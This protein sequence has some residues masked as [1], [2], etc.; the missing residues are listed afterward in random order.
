MSLN[1][2]D[3]RKVTSDRSIEN[4]DRFLRRVKGAIKDQLPDIIKD[5]SLKDIDSQGGKVR[6]KRK[7]IGEP[8]IHHGE[9]GE[10]DRVLPGNQKYV[11]DDMIPKP[12]EGA[13]RGRRASN[14]GEGE[15]DLIIDLSRDEFLKYFFEDLELPHLIETQLSKLKETFRENAG[16]QPDGSP[17]RLSVVR[18][19]KQSLVRRTAIRKTYEKELK[20]LEE[21]LSGLAIFDLDLEDKSPAGVLAALKDPS[22][23]AFPRA[24]DNEVA[25]YREILKKLSNVP[26]FEDMDLRYRSVITKEK[27]LSHA[28]MVMIMDNSGSM[29]QKEKTIARKFFWL[30]YSFL[31]SEYDEVDMIFISHTVVAHEMDEEEFFNTHESGGTL[32]SSALDLAAEIIQTRLLNKTNVYVAQVSDGDN[33][34]TDNGTCSEILEDDILPFTRYYAYVQVDNYHGMSSS[35]D[36]GLWTTYEGIASKSSNFQVKRVVEEKDIYPVFR[37]LFSKKIT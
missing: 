16:F 1:I 15:D 13:G 6:I 35:Y 10:T 19:Y 17:N 22:F 14:E 30:L 20:E 2:V 32:V 25:R 34:D 3:K 29:G 4:R 28:T 21:Q 12:Y 8:S 23:S 5:R 11:P 7:T 27:P 26:L 24:F 9:G 37:E 18:S 36:S 33:Y 31:R